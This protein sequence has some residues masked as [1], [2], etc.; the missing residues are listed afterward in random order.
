MKHIFPRN[1]DL[2]KMIIVLLLFIS[3]LIFVLVYLFS[4]RKTNI[5]VSNITDSRLVFDFYRTLYCSDEDLYFRYGPIMYHIDKFGTQRFEQF[6]SKNISDFAI[7][8][9]TKMF[10]NEKND[11]LD[12]YTDNILVGSVENVEKFSLYNNLIV[13]LTKETD[14]YTLSLYSLEGER[15][16]SLC[17]SESPIVFS[18]FSEGKLLCRLN[19]KF[20]QIDLN[21]YN[22]NEMYLN[23]PEEYRY[24]T[25]SGGFT[26]DGN[27]I[28]FADGIFSKCELAVYN[29]E[30][31][32]IIPIIEE[33][34]FQMSLSVAFGDNYIIYSSMDTDG[35]FPTNKGKK[36]GTWK[37]CFETNQDVKVNNNFYERLYS[38]SNGVIVKSGNSLKRLDI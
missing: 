19:K 3:A 5:T 18:S 30:S 2:K 34:S 22:M 1:K 9:N 21:T 23:V 37:Y 24:L 8:K 36:D 11:K 15:I 26:S 20:Y 33:P 28:V 12:I 7:N 31:N 25:E 10:L 6:I 35:L 17:T 13:I 38:V 29:I 16:A 32:I 4:P 14:T 27:S